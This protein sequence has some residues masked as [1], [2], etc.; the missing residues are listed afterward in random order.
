VARAR[1]RDTSDARRQA[2]A[3][4]EGLQ[5][6]RHRDPY[7]AGLARELETAQIDFEARAAAV[8]SAGNDVQ[9]AEAQARE[10]IRAQFAPRIE[11]AVRK[12]ER[13]LRA[14]AEANGELLALEAAERDAVG[15]Y[16][17][18]TLSLRELTPNDSGSSRIQTYAAQ[19][20]ATRG[21]K[22]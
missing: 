14:A 17:A 8:A 12:L 15:T 20:L 3:R 6:D 13:W 2:A 9:A 7:N 4:V 16:V 18:P 21:I 10:E 5:R 11:A 22:L 1:L 19:A